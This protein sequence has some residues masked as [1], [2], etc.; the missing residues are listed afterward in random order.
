MAPPL[1]ERPPVILHSVNTDRLLFRARLCPRTP[2]TPSTSSQGPERARRGPRPAEPNST[3]VTHV[4][5]RPPSATLQTT[6]RRAAGRVADSS[7]WCYARAWRSARGSA[8]AKPGPCPSNRLQRESVCWGED[9]PGPPALAGRSS[10]FNAVGRPDAVPGAY[11]P[12]APH[13][14]RPVASPEAASHLSRQSARLGPQLPTGPRRRLG[15][16]VG[17]STARRLRSRE[18]RPRLACFSGVLPSAPPERVI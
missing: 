14:R 5:P 2:L 7:P 6:P 13:S 10:A 12:S 18:G 9:P 15:H 3:S 16:V 8:P 4:V 17:W 11:G 1:P